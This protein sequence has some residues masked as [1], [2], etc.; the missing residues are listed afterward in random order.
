MRLL[1][2]ASNDYGNSGYWFSRAMER[3]GHECRYFKE[4][5]HVF[6]YGE[7]GRVATREEWQQ[8]GEHIRWAEVIHVIQSDL[9]VRMGGE[10]PPHEFL[11]AWL[12]RLRATVLIGVKFRSPHRASITDANQ[13]RPSWLDR[14]RGKR[15]VVLHGGSYYRHIPDFYRAIWDAVADRHVCYSADLMG[16][17]PGKEILVLPPIDTDAIR[18][19]E[20]SG[21]LTIGH[22]PSNAKIKGTAAIMSVV[23]GL[24]SENGHHAEFR[25]SEL[26]ASPGMTFHVGCK[27][28]PWKEQLVRTGA[29]DVVIDQLMPMENGR[30][31]GEWVSQATEASAMGCITITNSHRPG[32][33]R[34]TYGELPGLHVCNTPQAL[35]QELE[36]LLSLPRSVIA[37]EQERMR[38]WAIRCHSYERTAKIMEEQVYSWN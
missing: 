9:P 22:F 3:A 34:E 14:M 11:L 20:R 21:Q 17:F 12:R 15:I 6:Q 4:V 13:C 26:Q 30:P 2:L 25:C 8:M 35:R 29:C 7:E 28:V 33:Y 31:F 19:R 32:A 1:W 16:I 24:L 23:Q 27:T 36:I 37:K 10:H 18:P 5:P 38:A